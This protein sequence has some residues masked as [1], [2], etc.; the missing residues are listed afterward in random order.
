M[1]N[2]DLIT[3]DPD[4]AVR[5]LDLV[6]SFAKATDLTVDRKKTYG[7][8]TDAKVRKQ[9]R[10]ANIP[11][12]HAARDLGAHISYTRQFTNATVTARLA[13]LD[14]FWAALHK[15]PAPYAQ[16]VQAL[17]TVAWPRGLHA[18]SSAPIGRTKWISLRSKAAQSLLGRKAGLHPGLL[19]GLIE[20]SADPE[21]LALV[22]TVRYL[23]AFSTE[24]YIL[25]QLVPLALDFTSSPA[26]SPAQI[27]LTRLHQVGL[28]VSQ[29]G[30]VMDR[31]G[32]FDVFR[33]NYTE[34]L[35]RLQWAR[36]QKAASFVAHRSDF[37]GLPWADVLT[38]RRKLASL[39]LPHRAL[40]RL[41]LAGGSFTADVSSHWSDSGS[42]LCKWCGCTD[43]LYHR[44]WVCE[45]TRSIRERLAPDV[46]PLL[47]RLPQALLLRG[48]ALHCPSW[49][50]WISLL[51]SLPRDIPD[52]MTPLSL[53]AWNHVF[54]DGSCLWQ[55][56]PAFRIAAWSAVVASPFGASWSF[57]VQGI[58]GSSYLPGLCQSAFRAEL[59][60][61]AFTLHQ[62][63]VVGAR[64]NVWSDCL[65]VVNVF[66]LL[67]KGKGHVK[68]NSS[69]GDLWNWVLT[70]VD[71]LGLANIRVSKV[72]AHKRVASAT[73]R[74]EAWQWWNNGAADRTAKTSNMSR[75]P[76]FWRTWYRYVTEYSAAGK[77]HDQV[78]ATHMAVADLSVLGGKS[79]EPDVPSS[80]PR[81]GRSF[82]KYYGASLWNGDVPIGLL[83]KYGAGF[84][85]KIA[86]WWSTRNQ[87]STQ[88]ALSWIPLTILYVDYQ[89]TYGCVR[90]IKLG[91]NWAEHR[92]RPYLDVEKFPH[93]TRLRWFRAFLTTFLKHSGFRMALSTCKPDSEA[94]LAF[95]PSAVSWDRGCL[96]RAERWVHRHLKEPCTR[97][98]RVL[99]NLPPG[100]ADPAMAILSLPQTGS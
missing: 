11:V 33:G 72:Q 12:V 77:I 43:S 19:L 1:D 15:S 48:W 53:T 14:E 70:S 83:D 52:P 51:V 85:R 62:A 4:W 29:S 2:W 34:V 9:F 8:S 96:A 82:E 97:D 5:Q 99:R 26:N 36:H 25:E 94:I 57:G 81:A 63:A 41:S 87:F 74:F 68:P 49:P 61:F 88:E 45:A 39:D 27:L 67:T 31:F 90:P 37:T 93:T 89:L 55:A 7:W 58:L 3:W 73:T 32:V 18:V 17:R 22:A 13:A 59:Y 38:T 84:G 6:L 80:V 65:G 23:R 35:L 64:V 71:R 86:H 69:N 95:V 98:G 42:S 46:L 16:K 20:G 47:H 10:D 40:Y 44:Y 92:T 78:V 30:L 24:N 56:Y 28:S 79:D 54:T 21:E 100:I 91:K 50:D 75:P 60:G 66:H 76:T